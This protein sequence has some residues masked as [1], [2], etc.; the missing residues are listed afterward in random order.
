[1]II[2]DVISLIGYIVSV[3]ILIAA[4]IA[5]SVAMTLLSAQKRIIIIVAKNNAF[6]MRSGQTIGRLRV[7][8]TLR[9]GAGETVDIIIRNEDASTKHDWQCP[10]LGLH[11]R[12]LG[13]NEQQTLTV[14]MPMSECSLP[15]LCSI[16]HH[17]EAHEMRGRIE[18]AVLR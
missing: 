4:T 7:N 18:V 16:S 3:I 5:V 9:L 13:F 15:Y 11:S 8:P 12:A 14:T 10:A 1:M 2:A 6:Y 17:H